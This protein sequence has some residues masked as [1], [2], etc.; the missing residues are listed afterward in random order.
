MSEETSN[1]ALNSPY[2]KQSPFT[3]SLIEWAKVIVISILISLPIRYFI[4]EPF[5]V[6]GASMDPTFASGQFLIVDRLTYRLSSPERGDVI[7][8]EY[9][10]NPSIYY[11]KRIVGLPG[12]T[13]K[14]KDGVVTIENSDYPKGFVLKE[15][16]IDYSHK[17]N[18]T[19]IEKLSNDEYFVMGDNRDQS[20]DSRAWGPLET[21]YIV[22]K[23]AIRI[24]PLSSLSITPGQ[25][26]EKNK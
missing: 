5:V 10:N 12:E 26:H 21:K 1:T 19:Q 11:I 2:N 23:P 24:L 18:E 16:Y 25:Y 8:F 13:I 22:G 15:P 6:N 17:S 4:A 14:I 3:K 9:P 20:S 7:V